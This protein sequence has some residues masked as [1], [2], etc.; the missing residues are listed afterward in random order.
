M[1][2][3]RPDPWAIANTLYNWAHRARSGREEIIH[4]IHVA[5][6]PY[7]QTNDGANRIELNTRLATKNHQ[8]SEYVAEINE[9]HT[10]LNART[11]YRVRAVAHLVYCKGRFG[12]P[13]TWSWVKTSALSSNLVATNS[14]ELHLGQPIFGISAFRVA[15]HLTTQLEYWKPAAHRPWQHGGVGGTPEPHH[16]DIDP[17]TYD[18]LPALGGGAFDLGRLRWSIPGVRLRPTDEDGRIFHMGL[19]QAAKGRK[20]DKRS[21]PP[22]PPAG[23]KPKQQDIRKASQKLYAKYNHANQG[24]NQ[25]WPKLEDQPR[26]DPKRTKNLADRRRA[27]GRCT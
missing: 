27:G 20:Q 12:R 14:I 19:A 26:R 17:E 22:G 8:V 7:G 2:P 13:D 1:D 24:A 3:C 9:S 6:I 21:D 18:Y 23:A 25:R 16:F 5:F 11:K 15:P 4:T 10:D